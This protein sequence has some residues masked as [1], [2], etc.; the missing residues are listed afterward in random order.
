MEEV[1]RLR[2]EGRRL[3]R[4]ALVALRAAHPAEA[5]GRFEMF[6][7]DERAA[8]AERFEAE[9][10]EIRKRGC[11]VLALRPGGGGP[12]HIHRPDPARAARQGGLR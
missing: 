5:H 11:E 4:E 3:D 1:T 8:L 9:L 12:D 10:A 2:A 7:E 6:S